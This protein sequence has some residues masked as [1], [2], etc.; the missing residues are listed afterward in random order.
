MRIQMW[1]PNGRA[2]IEVGHDQVDGLK[3]KGF[4][5]YDP[6]TKG[7]TTSDATAKAPKAKKSDKPK[8]SKED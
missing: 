6:A 1:T 4:T 8:A 7:L 5:T 3:A 2:S